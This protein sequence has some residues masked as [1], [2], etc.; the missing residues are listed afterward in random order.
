PIDITASA[1]DLL[2]RCQSGRGIEDSP[3]RV[4]KDTGNGWDGD[5]LVIVVVKTRDI[6]GAVLGRGGPETQLIGDKGLRFQRGIRHQP[7]EI[8]RSTGSKSIGRYAVE[9]QVTRFRQLGRGAYGS[10]HGCPYAAIIVRQE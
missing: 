5:Q 8:G 10:G 9:V 2:E 3:I 1:V 4:G 6:Q 7:L